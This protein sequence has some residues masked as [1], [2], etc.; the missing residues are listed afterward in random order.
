MLRNK[1]DDRDFGS[2]G[3]ENQRG[4]AVEDQGLNLNMNIVASDT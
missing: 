4:F 2:E 3:F 1:K